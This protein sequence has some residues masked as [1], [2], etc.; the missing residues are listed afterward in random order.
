MKSIPSHVLFFAKDYRPIDDVGVARGIV[1][2]EI[3]P[4]WAGF[5]TGDFVEE[6]LGGGRA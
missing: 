3:R 6:K 4:W 1:L 5:E 2:Y